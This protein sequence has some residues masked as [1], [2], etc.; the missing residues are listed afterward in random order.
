LTTQSGLTPA[1]KAAVRQIASCSA[2]LRSALAQ[3]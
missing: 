2:A 3:E 1:D